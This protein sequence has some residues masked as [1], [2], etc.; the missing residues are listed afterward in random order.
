V[1]PRYYQVYANDDA[2]AQRLYYGALDD[3]SISIQQFSDDQ[4]EAYFFHTN[5]TLGDGQYRRLDLSKVQFVS[6]KFTNTTRKQALRF[7]WPLN[8]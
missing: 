4:P 8:S 5:G 2:D 7:S 1:R 6:N 3:D